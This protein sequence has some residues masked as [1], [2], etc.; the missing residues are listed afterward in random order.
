MCGWGEEEGNA[1]RPQYHCTYCD[2]LGY[3]GKYLIEKR[4]CDGK[5]YSVHLLIII[6][7]RGCCECEFAFYFYYSKSLVENRFSPQCEE[8]VWSGKSFGSSRFLINTMKTSNTSKKMSRN[9]H[10]LKS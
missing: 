6:R 4:I 2:H 7:F 1:R 8:C 10:T 9:S 5:K 3:G